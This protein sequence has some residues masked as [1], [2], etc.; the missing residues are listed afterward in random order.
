MTSTVNKPLTRAVKYQQDPEWLKVLPL[1]DTTSRELTQVLKQVSVKFHQADVLQW[2]KKYESAQEKT[3]R[4]GRSYTELNDLI[5]GVILTDNLQQAMAVVSFLLRLPNCQIIKWEA[6]T[7]SE[8]SPYC[9]ALHVDLR[10]GHLTC[11]IQVMPKA[12]WKVKKAHN[13]YYKTGRPME[14]ADMWNGVQNF[15][16]QQLKLMGV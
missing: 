4:K 1:I 6:K 14:G 5:K 9:G 11:E 7:G 8:T 13:H 2:N 16:P 12:T 3:V 10:L 15:T